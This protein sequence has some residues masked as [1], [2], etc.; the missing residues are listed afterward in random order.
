MLCRL[1][2]GQHRLHTGVLTLK[3]VLSLRERLI[4]DFFLQSR[5]QLLLMLGVLA[6]SKILYLTQPKRVAKTRRTLGFQATD[7]QPAI[8][9]GSIVVVERPPFS[10]AVSAPAP[11]RKTGSTGHGAQ[12]KGRIGHADI[13]KLP[14]SGLLPL[15]DGGEDAHGS[16]VR[17]TSNVHTQWGGHAVRAT[18]VAVHPGQHE[19][20]DVVACPVRLGAG[21][22]ETGNGSVDES[23]IDGFQRFI[24][25]PE[26]IHDVA[27]ATSAS[28]GEV[29]PCH[30][31]W[32][33][34]KTGQPE[35]TSPN[36]GR[37][38]CF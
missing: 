35:M 25:D 11:A 8:V 16:M 13:H 33:K 23:R 15:H 36:L 14:F 29:R 38:F 21:R 37:V 31:H 20:I 22:A 24:I 17:T 5:L 26:M 9:P 30:R 19:V 1:G 6:Q 34:T 27:A 4:Q 2:N 18:T 3:Y 12:R 32:T 10:S 7:R 28:L